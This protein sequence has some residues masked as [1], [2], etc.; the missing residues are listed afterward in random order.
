MPPL[1]ARN[2]P[3]RVIGFEPAFKK[4]GKNDLHN[5]IRFCAIPQRSPFPRNRYQG[6]FG[7]V[8]LRRPR[9]IKLFKWC[10]KTHATAINMKIFVFRCG[11]CS[12]AAAARNKLLLPRE[13]SC[14]RREKQT[15]VATGN[16][17][18]LLCEISHPL[19]E[20]TSLKKNHKNIFE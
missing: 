9:E 11:R 4:Q 7:A 14:D 10:V 20:I 13:N 16:N 15:A 19:L 8:L 6:H 17:L 1:R 12:V 3:G 2:S 5:T 18:R